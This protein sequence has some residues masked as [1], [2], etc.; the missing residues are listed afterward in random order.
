[1][2]LVVIVLVRSVPQGI[3]SLMGS[4]KFALFSAKLV[5]YLLGNNCNVHPVMIH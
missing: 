5:P 1:M 2:S 3:I 4:A